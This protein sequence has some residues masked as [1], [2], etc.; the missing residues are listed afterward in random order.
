MAL[1]CG[2]SGLVVA[3]EPNPHVFRVLEVNAA[4]NAGRAARVLPL[5]VAATEDDGEFEFHYWDASFGNGGYLS[6]LHNQRHGHRYPLRVTGRN[7]EREVRARI[8]DRLSRLALIKIDAE[9]YDAAVLHSMRGLIDQFRPALVC[10]VHKKLDHAERQHLYDEVSR[11]RYSLHRYR[12]GGQ[13]LGE[14]VGAD[15]LSRWPHFDMVAMP[16]ERTT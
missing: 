6:R 8:A 10:E 4:L 2:P 13:P 3:V 12:G 14:S 9:G 5:N 11:P 7:L 1:A 15:D 16:E